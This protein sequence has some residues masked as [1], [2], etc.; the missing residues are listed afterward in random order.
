M[1]MYLHATLG[2]PNPACLVNSLQYVGFAPE[3]WGC[4]YFVCMDVYEM[5]L[6]NN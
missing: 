4:V 2:C 1:W 6:V 3:G 5:G